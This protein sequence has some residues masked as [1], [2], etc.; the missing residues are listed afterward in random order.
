MLGFIST[1]LKSIPI[2][3]LATKLNIISMA[4]YLIGYS[5]WY[6]ATFMYPNHPK[7]KKNWY[8][9]ASYKYQYQA[10]AFLGTLATLMCIFTPFVAITAAWI[11]ALSNIIWVIGEH[12]K[13]KFQIKQK[14]EDYSL[15]K[16]SLYFR[17]TVLVAIGST[18]SALFSTAV[19][20]IPEAAF[21]IN[22]LAFVLSLFFMFTSLTYW[23]KAAFYTPAA[24]VPT[25]MKIKD[26]YEQVLDHLNT[27]PHY[28]KDNPSVG[29]RP[30]DSRCETPT[31]L[32]IRSTR[33]QS[34]YSIQSA[35]ESSN[36]HIAKNDE[37]DHYGQV[38]QL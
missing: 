16:Q 38:N 1:R 12:H 2:A 25:P 29:E 33:E 15:E 7:L 21:F 17:F 27:N 32:E 22:P 6:V 24:S 10:A 5:A 34:D 26:T 18:L 3:V 14:D 8:G 35:F 9:F 4:A 30:N 28:F 19:I 20:L 36:D 11:Y 13:N 31:D 37:P 23:G